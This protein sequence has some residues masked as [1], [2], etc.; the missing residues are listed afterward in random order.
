MRVAQHDSMQHSIS[1][2]IDRSTN[3]AALWH[4][5]CD[6]ALYIH[7]TWCSVGRCF[8]TVGARPERVRPSV[9]Q[10]RTL[11]RV[12]LGESQK[13][14]A[15]DLDVSVTTIA[16]AAMLGLSGLMRRCRVS[17]AP[18]LLVTAAFAARGLATEHA[19]F[20]QMVDEGSWIISI[21]V[22]GAALQGRLSPA[23]DEVAQL[24]IQG[25]SHQGIAKIRGT[26]TRTVANQL[27]SVFGKIGVR[28]RSELRAHAVRGQADSRRQSSNVVATP[29]EFR[30]AGSAARANGWTISKYAC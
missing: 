16:T 28:G 5:L 3:L 2:H 23:E 24:S 1:E 21:P 27:A 4:Q 7:E 18:I 14:V 22:P 6:G 9:A 12:L 20:E 29:H 11:E 25:E 17:N 15:I 13:S 8:V 26:S 10:L 19:R 30:Q